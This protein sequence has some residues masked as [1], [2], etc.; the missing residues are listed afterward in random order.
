MRDKV[1]RWKLAIQHFDFDVE[2]IKGELNIEADGFSRLI[3]TIDGE[4][5]EFVVQNTINALRTVTP[6]LDMLPPAIYNKIMQFHNATIGHHGVE[7]TLQKLKESDI[8]W[9]K[10]RKD[11][12]LFIERCPCCQK[13]SVLKPIIHTKPFTLA[14]YSPFDRICVDTIGPLP[15]DIDSGSE[16][17]LVIIDAFSR[18]VKLYPVKDTSAKAAL[19]SLIDWM[20]MFGIPS[21]VVSDNGTQFANELITCFLD[22][23]GTT[24]VKIHAYSKEE[25]GMVERANK[26]VNRHLRTLVYNR[27]VKSKWTTYLLTINTTNNEC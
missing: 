17:I 13:M 20:G 22:T 3:E 10:M 7:R 5:R 24:N 14:S 4:P 11:V 12:K 21:E 1:K 15:T 8:T 23:L 6:E 19:H 25:N 26:E 18:F 9:K 2:H 16:Y 27:K